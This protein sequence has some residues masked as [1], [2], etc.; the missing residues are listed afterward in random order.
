LGL[1][2]FGAERT[3]VAE[4]Y[5]LSGDMFDTEYTSKLRKMSFLSSEQ[6]LLLLRGP[7]FPN[8]HHQRYVRLALTMI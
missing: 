8:P 3:E 4:K 1:I 5:I 2:E 7:L 6:L